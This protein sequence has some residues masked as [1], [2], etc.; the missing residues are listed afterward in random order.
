MTSSYTQPEHRPTSERT[1]STCLV[2][3]ELLWEGS[4]PYSCEFEEIYFPNNAVLHSREVFLAGI[5]APQCWRGHEHY[6]IGETG[7]GGG[8]NFLAT[9]AS[10][11]SG[12]AS[13]RLQY[14]AVENRPLDPASLARIHAGLP[15]FAVLSGELRRRWPP[16]WRGVHRLVLAGGRVHLLL[17]FGD[18]QAMLARL[19]ARVDAWYL[20]GFA[21]DR[22]P[23]MW[24]TGVAREIARLSAPGAR[25]ASCSVAG[26]VRRAFSEAGFRLERLP[27][28]DGKRGRLAGE[29]VVPPPTPCREAPWFHLPAPRPG[30]VAII[31]SGIAGSSVAAACRDLGLEATI[32]A[33]EAPDP[34][35]AAAFLPRPD[36][37]PHAPGRL[38]LQAMADALRCHDAGA[39]V[40]Q[41]LRGALVPLAT[42]RQLAHGMT[43]CDRIGPGD[44][45]PR[46]LEPA[47]ASVAAGLTLGVPALF[48][49][50]GGMIDVA[51]ALR[52]LAGGCRRIRRAVATVR[53]VPGGW[54]LEDD[55]GK[56]LVEAPNLVIAA[57]IA[58]AGLTGAALPGLSGQPGSLALLPPDEAPAR[59]IGQ[60]GLLGPTVSTPRGRLRLLAG[61]PPAGLV[62]DLPAAFATWRGVRAVARDHLPFAGPVPDYVAFAKD[63]AP[64]VHDRRR[65]GLPPPVLR[66]GLFVLTGLGARGFQNATLMAASIAAAIAGTPQPVE[67]AQREAVHPARLFMRDLIRRRGNLSQ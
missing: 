31:G 26:Q 51:V 15:E 8:L 47:E 25:L 16:P 17:A 33:P 22:N 30:P 60:G 62:A 44:S 32:I 28:L 3:P 57:G 24:S 55:E 18:A 61:P 49:S 40:W 10:F 64:A 21:P 53:P 19:E 56:S 37:G 34:L 7:F 46:L 4:R 2:T 11:L 12:P 14:L 23:A 1:E 66:E 67:R 20:D 45:A 35:L 5:G 9:C 42:P 48:W 38:L 6:V 58:T 29:L 39:G 43:L 54:R 59:L 52:H 50:A 13:G 41:G 65:R 27:G 36:I 63:Y